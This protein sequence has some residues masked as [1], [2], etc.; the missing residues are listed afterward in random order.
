M[1]F[2]NK[3]LKRRFKLPR[4]SP[5]QTQSQRPPSQATKVQFYQNCFIVAFS[6]LMGTIW[7]TGKIFFEDRNEIARLKDEND[8][9][10]TWWNEEGRYIASTG[11]E[12]RQGAGAGNIENEGNITSGFD[13]RNEQAKAT[14]ELITFNERLHRENEEVK[15]DLRELLVWVE[16]RGQEGVW[17]N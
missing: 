1:R 12:T 11:N 6:S 4:S 2:K 9:W 10:R 16:K 17:K 5:T 15:K 14:E 8:N 7:F 3:N 13:R